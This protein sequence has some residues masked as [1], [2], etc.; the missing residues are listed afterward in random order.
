MPNWSSQLRLY[1]STDKA[2]SLTRT[3]TSTFNTKQN[4]LTW[5]ND[6][7]IGPDLL[8]LVFERREENVDS[9][10]AALVGK[11]TTNSAGAAYLLKRGRHLANFSARG[12]DSSQFGSHATGS[13]GYGYRIS[14]A[15]R[16]NAGFG[17]SFRAPTF[18]E[19]YFP[20]FGIA[21]NQPEEGRNAEIG[22]H[23][24]DRKTQFSAAYYRNRISN[25]I[26]NTNPC[27]VNPGAYAYGC[28]YNVNQALL[29]GVTIGAA[30]RV[31]D[32]SVRGALDFQ[33]PRDETTGKSLARRAKRHG[34]VAVEY[35]ADRIKAGVDAVFSGRRFD[36]AGN[37][38]SMGGYGLLNLYASVDFGRDWSLFGRWN[39]VLNK[40]YELAKN[41]ATAGSNVFVGLR[42]DLGALR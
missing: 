4:D 37:T 34:S 17:T 15:L 22:L 30:T 3:G 35:G 7:S 19:S 9:T 14:E 31:G 21:A 29:T 5:Q 2:D 41:Y 39:N 36:N 16:A 32:F 23:Y 13:A 18:N 20:G 10:T 26:V 1:Q 25:L 24:D 6:V 27:P 8:Q 12:D 28:A 11:R 42:Y 33:D 38:V 40:D